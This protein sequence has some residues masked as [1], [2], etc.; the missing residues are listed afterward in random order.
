LRARIDSDE[1]ERPADI[2]RR[3]YTQKFLAEIGGKFKFDPFTR[4][5]A[6]DL[7]WIARTYILNRRLEISWDEHGRRMQSL[8]SY[9][10]FYKVTVSFLDW[11]KKSYDHADFYNIATEMLLVA[12]NRGE[13]DPQNEFP[14]LDAHRRSVEAYYRELVRLTEILEATLE[15][16]ILNATPRRGPRPDD[17]LRHFVSSCAAFWMADLKRRFTIDSHAGS[18]T[19]RSFEFVK[20]LLDPLDEIDD[21]KIVTAIR[22]ENAAM[23]LPN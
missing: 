11:L 23:S 20:R 17:T 2:A 8:K 16:G 10:E 4:N 14:K 19:T 12:R 1:S 6:S 7:R 18:G 22:A 21:K 13:S 15:R 3:V 5:R 9:R